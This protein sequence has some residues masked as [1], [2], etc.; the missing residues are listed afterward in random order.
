MTAFTPR[1]A[2]RWRAAAAKI[3]RRSADRSELFW[4]L[5][6]SGASETK[7]VESAATMKK[8]PD[9]VGTFYSP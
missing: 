6:G 5:K 7:G 8:L 9:S 4:A 2:A 1:I 3:A